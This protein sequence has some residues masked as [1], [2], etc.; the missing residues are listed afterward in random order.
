MRSHFSLPRGVAAACAV[1]GA[2]TMLNGNCSAQ[3]VAADYATNST[4][5]SGWTNGQNGGY[6]FGAWSF[7]GTN[8]D[9][10]TNSVGVPYQYQGIGTSS[11]I[12]TA[13]TLLTYSG[14]QNGSG[15]ANAGRAIN[16]GL[17]PG[18]TF[19]AVLQNPSTWQ[20]MYAY[21][22]FDLL[23]TAGPDNN[24]GGDNTNAL[25]VQVFDYFNA[26]QYWAITDAD[27]TTHLNGTVAPAFPAALTAAEGMKLDFTLT[28][29]TSYSLTLTPL[30]GAT[31]Y[32]QTGTLSTNITWFN[33]RSYNGVSAGLTD[34]ANNFSI[35]SMTIAVP[36]PATLSILKDG[37]NVLLS[38]PGTF[39]NF[40]LVY[41]TNLSVPGWT[42]VST[43]PSIVNGQNVVTN[44]IVGKQQFFRLQQQ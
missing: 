39:T 26:N 19:E 25:R 4:Y 10:L 11:P 2:S 1:A 9:P 35:S 15:L 41:S 32:S 23:F 42:A 21:R 5:A 12:G 30:N 3:L 16:G 7:N 20:G 14:G 13:W 22:G 8:P 33:F 24:P 18:Q 40:N 17:Q 38:W 31:P 37:S 29:T 36:P 6:G 34:T 27:G 43:T 28:S 44:P